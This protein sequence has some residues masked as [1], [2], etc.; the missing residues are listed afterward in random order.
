MR[1]DGYGRQLRLRDE[2]IGGAIALLAVGGLGLTGP[3]VAPAAAAVAFTS[4]Q[5]VGTAGGMATSVAAADLNHDSRPDLVATSATAGGVDVVLGRA[6][7]SFAFPD[8]FATGASP[9]KVRIAELNGDNH[10]D[11]AVANEGANTVSVLLGTGSG[12]FGPARSLSVGPAPSDVGIGD[13]DDDGRPD[14]VTANS[15]ANT[16]SLLFADGARSFQPAESFVVA[17]S[18][19][20]LAVAD[21]DNDGRPDLAVGTKVPGAVTVL[22]GTGDDN[23]PFNVPKSTSV[24]PAPLALAAADL[25][26]GDGKLDL[27][28]AGANT[29]LLYGTGNGAFGSYDE[30]P[31]AGDSAAVAVGDFDGDSDSDV[32]TARPAADRIAVL[33]GPHPAPFPALEFPAGDEPVSIAVADF[34]RDGMPDLAVANKIATGTLSVLLNAPAPTAS[35]AALAFE[36]TTAQGTV[37]P[38]R[39][40]TFANGGSAPL[41]VSGFWF[42]GA[43]AEDFLVSSHSCHVPVQPGASCIASVRFAP[44]TP[45][46]RT[47]TIHAATNAPTEPTV[48]L[49]GTAV[50][51]AVGP[52]G[53]AGMVGPVGAAGPQGA[54]GVPG[55]PG[56]RGAPGP[57]ATVTCKA[58]KA[59]N[60]KKV[61]VL[62]TVKASAKA[63]LARLTHAGHTVA[64]RVIA[65]GVRRVV[66]HLPRGK[67]GSYHLVMEPR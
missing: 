45:G 8:S 27:V 14:L 17:T 9:S 53:P 25:N 42:S 49:S 10:L 48:S 38:P 15:G 58:S 61:K 13:F 21:F 3:L 22:P 6:G 4:P 65:A 35:P 18:P 5:V 43:G 30:L 33:R 16:I 56:A 39:T 7:G 24:P 1:S 52:T 32:V 57:A 40:L 50:A 2:L 23:A 66:F 19:S 12:S 26:D 20:S 55:E 47:A 63:S 34:N 51:L 29:V 11:I 54:P 36:G 41:H 44:Q 46:V 37:G 59:A 62:C 64:R 28:S 67:R 60:A 31:S